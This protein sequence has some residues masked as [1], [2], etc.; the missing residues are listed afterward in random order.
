MKNKK[1]L[2]LM[3][4]VMLSCPAYTVDAATHYQM[5]WGGNE[6]LVQTGI[7]LT[8]LVTLLFHNIMEFMQMEL[9]LQMLATRIT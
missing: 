7:R 3:L 1:S 4:A 9:I 2:Q 5:I 6:S 8:L